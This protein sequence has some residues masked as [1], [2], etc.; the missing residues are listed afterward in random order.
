L[1]DRI[2]GRLREEGFSVLIRRRD[3]FSREEAKAFYRVH[4]GKPFFNSLVDFMSSGEI[5]ALLLERESA[6]SALRGAIGATDPAEAEKGTIRSEY[7]ESKERNAIHASDS[8]ETAEDEVA[9]F[10]SR[11]EVIR[12][13]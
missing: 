2:I 11:L 13:R 1:E 10:F 9:F 5:V 12:A 8:P 6:V 7:A 3:R 4:E